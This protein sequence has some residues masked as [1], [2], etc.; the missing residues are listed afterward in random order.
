MKNHTHLLDHQRSHGDT[1]TIGL[2]GIM[3]WVLQLNNSHSVKLFNSLLEKFNMLHSPNQ[4]NQKPKPICD[5]SG[6]PER[7]SED[8]RVKHAHDG[9][10]QPVE[11][12]CSSTN[13]V[14]EQFVPEENRDIASFDADNEFKPCNRRREH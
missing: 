7:L 5:R 13:I 9:T 8:I 14:E 11:S 4:P 1:I 6:K 10:G 12:S 3:N 2:E